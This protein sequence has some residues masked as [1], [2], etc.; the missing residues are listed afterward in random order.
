MKDYIKDRVYIAKN[1]C[2]IWTKSLNENGYGKLE[3]K[4]KSYKA[5]RFSYTAFKRAISNNKVIRHTCDCRHCV[6]PEHLII[7]TQL[8]N[9]QDMMKR[10]RISK[11][12]SVKKVAIINGIEYSSI[13]EASKKLGLCRTTIVGKIKK[14]NEGC[15]IARI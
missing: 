6:N 1:G 13:A 11:E 12:P 9:V 4:G 8:K 3:Y 5:H 10:G 2:W 15:S 14:F 7:G